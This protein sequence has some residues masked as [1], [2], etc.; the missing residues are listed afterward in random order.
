MEGRRAGGGGAK[1]EGGARFSRGDDELDAC[2]VGT[3]GSRRTYQLECRGAWSGAYDAYLG[4]GT[5][6][7]WS[8]LVGRGPTTVPTN[9]GGE[10]VTETTGLPG[11]RAS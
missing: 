1:W 10:S 5:L 2:T 7:N 3:V 11:A 6:G 4:G 9:K 8:S